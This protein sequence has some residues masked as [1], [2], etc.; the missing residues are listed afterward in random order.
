MALRLIDRGATLVGDDQILIN[1][2]GDALLASPASNIHGILEV[3]GIGIMHLPYEQDVPV[4]LAVKLVAREAV[5]RMPYAKF[6]DCLGLQLPLLLLH[7]FDSSTPAKIR[8][9]LQRKE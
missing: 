9:Y 7:A 4:A 3:R 2:V 8:V 6:F 1:K 5:E